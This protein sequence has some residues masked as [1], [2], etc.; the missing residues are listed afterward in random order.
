MLTEGEHATLN[1]LNG[2]GVGQASWP[3][4]I[5]WAEDQCS[6]ALPNGPGVVASSLAKDGRGHWQLL[7]G[8]DKRARA[9]VPHMPV[10]VDCFS[11]IKRCSWGKADKPASS[12]WQGCLAVK[13]LTVDPLSSYPI[14][15]RHMHAV[16]NDAA[17]QNK[18][19]SCF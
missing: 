11:S 10:L 17:K 2:L 3:D 6:Q 15:M 19:H 9:A 18:D 13:H 12:L 1:T 4:W 7:Q 14:C 16:I 5:Q 8:Y